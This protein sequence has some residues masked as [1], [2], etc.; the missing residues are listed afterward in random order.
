L[1]E[2]SRSQDLA[3]HMTDLEMNFTRYKVR[4]GL[5]ATSF[6]LGRMAYRAVVFRAV[7]YAIWR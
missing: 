4:V 1:D 6:L 5:L 3:A 7:I 2:A